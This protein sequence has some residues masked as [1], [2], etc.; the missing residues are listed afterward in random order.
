MTLALNWDPVRSTALEAERPSPQELCERYADRVYRFAAL[1]GRDALEAEDL[2]Q[3]A[4]EKAIRYLHTYDP[5]K[6]ELERWLFRIVVN[7]ARDAGRVARRRHLLW[8]RL[9]STRPSVE[10][11]SM[12]IADSIADDSILAAVRSLKPRD[13]ALVALRF[14]AD[15]DYATVGTHMGLSAAAAQVATSRALALLRRQLEAA[16]TE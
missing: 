1:V 4:L 15:L 3:D 13:R 6:G 7:A 10:A 14:G 8:E 11:D 16:G 9:V 5:A 2:A 12:D